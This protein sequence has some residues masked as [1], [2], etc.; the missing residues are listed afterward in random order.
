MAMMFAGGSSNNISQAK[1]R[2]N[3]PAL[4]HIVERHWPTSGSKNAGKFSDGSARGL[5]DLI[6]EA[7]KRGLRRPDRYGR[8]R[9]VWDF[10][11]QIGIN[12]AGGIATK[13]RIIIERWGDVVTAFPV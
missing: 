8:T 5:L 2:L 12:S 7:G 1:P 4:E 3:Q 10:G 6:K 13:I 11:R 9:I